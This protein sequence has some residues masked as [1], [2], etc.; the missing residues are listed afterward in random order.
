MG[1]K[2]EVENDKETLTLINKLMG[3]N[4]SQISLQVINTKKH[5]KLLRIIFKI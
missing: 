5:R 4:S 2:I 1:L 3:S